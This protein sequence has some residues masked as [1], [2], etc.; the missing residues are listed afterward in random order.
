MRVPWTVQS[1]WITPP[2]QVGNG[3]RAL[4]V[5]GF[6]WDCTFALALFRKRNCVTF[7]TYTVFAVGVSMRME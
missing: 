1:Y 3:S 6:R 7:C 5:V 2:V 4:P